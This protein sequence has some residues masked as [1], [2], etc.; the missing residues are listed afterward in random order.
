MKWKV[1]VSAPYMQP[2]VMKIIDFWDIDLS[3]N[4][5]KFMPKIVVILK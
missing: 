4:L 1:L 2:G 3:K 5:S